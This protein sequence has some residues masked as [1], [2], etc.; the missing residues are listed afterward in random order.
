M[1]WAYLL[2]G[3]SG[4]VADAPW[5]SMP[6]LA[7]IRRA[8]RLQ[9]QQCSDGLLVGPAPVLQGRPIRRDELADPEPCRD[10]PRLQWF[11]P[12]SMPALASLA[13]QGIEDHPRI[14]LHCGICCHVA[15]AVSAPRKIVFGVGD[16]GATQGHYADDYGRAAARLYDLDAELA[17]GGSD[18]AGD[19]LADEY[20]RA[21][22]RCL[23]LAIQS[24]YHVTE[25]MLTLGDWITT[26]DIPAII[27][28]MWG[29]DQ[30]KA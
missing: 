8:G 22:N 15:P 19:V 26:A 10:N 3:W 13:R 30:G 17:E 25:E 1:A 14:E 18:Q 16:E 21:L 29:I 2:S 27:R 4:S 7:R 28:V 12:R 24:C 5:R 23:V 9:G 6:E 20:E 11:A